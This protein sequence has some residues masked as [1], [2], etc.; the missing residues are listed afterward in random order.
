MRVVSE[1]V[2]PYWQDS[3][4]VPMSGGGRVLSCQ[5]KLN[6]MAIWVEDDDAL[7][8]APVAFVVHE[9]DEEIQA[10]EDYVTTFMVNRRDPE[11]GAT[12]TET[13]HIYR[14]R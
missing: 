13:R 3:F 1:H 11:S 5:A 12:E 7:P 2:V 8:L 4:V 14:V 10:N 6:G 9:N